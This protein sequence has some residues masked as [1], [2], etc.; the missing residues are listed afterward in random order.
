MKIRYIFIY[1]KNTNTCHE[2]VI[3]YTGIIFKTTKIHGLKRQQRRY[4]TLERAFYN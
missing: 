1:N 3:I 4:H 2:A